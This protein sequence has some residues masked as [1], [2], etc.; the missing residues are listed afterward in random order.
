M[1]KKKFYAVAVGATPGIYGNWPEAQAQVKGFGGAKYKGFVTRQEATQ[2]LNAVASG[3]EMPPDGSSKKA[4]KNKSMKVSS[5][6]ST[7]PNVVRVYTD[8][9]SI[10]NPGPGGWGA[11][12]VFEGHEIE[13]SGGFQLTTNNRMEL[14]ACIMALE[15]LEFRHKKIMLYSDSSYVVNGFEKGWAKSWRR[16]NWLKSDKQ[17][18]KNSDLWRRLLDISE[19]IDVTFNW[20]KGHA[21]NVYNERC[22][23]LA[24]Q[25]ARKESDI[26]DQ[27]YEGNV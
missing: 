1:A 2:W 22:D 20:V 6:E 27:G 24:V 4:S 19:D 12:I 26:V 10:N 15:K 13:Y 17:P 8:G 23:V 18:A 5:T 9:G 11:V 14:M 3:Q 16:N 25:E 21:G 7:D